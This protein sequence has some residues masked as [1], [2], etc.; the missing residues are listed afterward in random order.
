MTTLLHIFFWCR[1]IAERC[2]QLYIEQQI[3]DT[4]TRYMYVCSY[5]CW[6]VASLP[7][8]KTWSVVQYSS[9]QNLGKEKCCID[10]KV[11]A[12]NLL[13]NGVYHIHSNLWNSPK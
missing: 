12:R 2:Q 5:N 7:D 1:T 6:S 10:F 13:P 9:V 11:L 4:K 3:E 8:G